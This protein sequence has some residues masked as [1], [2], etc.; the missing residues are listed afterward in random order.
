MMHDNIGMILKTKLV[1]G[2]SRLDR[3]WYSTWQTWYNNAFRNYIV[4]FHCW[5][6][7]HDPVYFLHGFIPLS[8]NWMNQNWN[9][10]ETYLISVAQFGPRT[11]TIPNTSHGQPFNHCLQGYIF[12]L[13]AFLCT[14][15]ATGT[16]TFMVTW[17]LATKKC[18]QHHLPAATFTVEAIGYLAIDVATSFHAHYS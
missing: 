8:K 2:L 4:V 1:Q 18:G 7:C 15:A 6:F 13:C 14:V 3:I 11:G 16:S 12:A 5:K 17:Y 10:T 9:D